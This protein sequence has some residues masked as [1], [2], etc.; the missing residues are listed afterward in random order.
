MADRLTQLQ[1]C[2]DQLLTQFYA[3]LRYLSSHHDSSPLDPQSNNQP[4]YPAS[5]T[6][7]T[8]RVDS[9]ADF[10]AAQKELAQDL[11]TKTK[12]IE[13]LI[14][15]LPGLESSEQQQEERIGRLEMELREAEAERNRA[16]KEKE[17]WMKE[18]DMAIMRVRR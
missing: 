16:V 4:P 3:S 13:Y 7:P 18:L 12:Q 2:L 9:P 1:D 17:A 8:Q 15:V 14:R 10:K 6:A 11:V 5:D